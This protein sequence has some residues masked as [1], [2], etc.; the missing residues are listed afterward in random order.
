MYKY[1][2]IYIYINIHTCTYMYVIYY[3][4]NFLDIKDIGEVEGKCL[5][6]V[7]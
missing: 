3:G 7:G 4:F 2:Y 6:V 5:V 1:I